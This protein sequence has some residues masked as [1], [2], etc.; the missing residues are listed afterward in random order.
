MEE[1]S[2]SKKPRLGTLKSKKYDQK[3][4]PFENQLV[5]LMKNKQTDNG[6]E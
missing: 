1:E 2:H 6:S 4:S 5:D 3:M